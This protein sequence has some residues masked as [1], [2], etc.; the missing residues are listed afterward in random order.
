MGKCVTKK[1]EKKEHRFAEPC[2]F[3]PKAFETIEVK[4]D[5]YLTKFFSVVFVVVV[6]CILFSLSG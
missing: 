5:V 4:R 3:I 6:V 1:K 2:V